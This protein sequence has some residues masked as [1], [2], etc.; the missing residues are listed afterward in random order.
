M[1]LVLW[2]LCLH[3]S[4]HLL[5][6][7][8]RVEANKIQRRKRMNELNGTTSTTDA[9]KKL[10]MEEELQ[11]KV[12]GLLLKGKKIK[13]KKERRASELPKNIHWSIYRRHISSNQHASPFYLWPLIT[14]LRPY[15]WS[16][17][18]SFLYFFRIE[19]YG[20]ENTWI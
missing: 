16:F 11:T 20:T 3:L 2:L 10:L 19:I 17:F 13:K 4:Q 6:V 9:K 7:V 14:Y 15:V 18:Y 8:K 12:N 5:C 1:I